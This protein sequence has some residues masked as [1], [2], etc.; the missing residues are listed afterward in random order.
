MNIQSKLMGIIFL[1]DAVSVGFNWYEHCFKKL[2]PCVSSVRLL[3][4]SLSIPFPLKI[5]LG[6]I[7]ILDYN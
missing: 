7:I 1:D 4:S 6:R 2:M 3:E 5:K